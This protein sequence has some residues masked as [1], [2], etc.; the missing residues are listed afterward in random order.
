MIRYCTSRDLH[1]HEIRCACHD[2]KCDTV[3]T[4]D[5]GDFKR[6]YIYAESP[7]FSRKVSLAIDPFLAICIEIAFAMEYPQEQAHR[8]GSHWFRQGDGHVSV[9][10]RSIFVYDDKDEIMVY[11][12]G[13]VYNELLHQCRMFSKQD[14]FEEV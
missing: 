5:T 3:V 12:P 1:V 9:G 10:D 2:P 13:A 11:L 4:I 14:V 7:R 6:T 8:E